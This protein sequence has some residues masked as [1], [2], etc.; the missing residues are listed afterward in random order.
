MKRPRCPPADELIINGRGVGVGGSLFSAA[1]GKHW[2]GATWGGKGFISAN[3]LSRRKPGQE[4]KEGTQKQKLSIPYF[5]FL[6]QRTA[7]AKFGF[8]CGWS[9]TCN[10]NSNFSAPPP[11]SD[12]APVSILPREVLKRS[13]FLTLLIL[14]SF[15]HSFGFSHFLI[16]WEISSVKFPGLFSGIGRVLKELSHSDTFIHAL[17]FLL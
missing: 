2:P 4:F 8:P 16:V 13:K 6:S 14:G 9:P 12:P 11:G 17:S 7:P 3:S 1:V 15:I 10:F 5:S